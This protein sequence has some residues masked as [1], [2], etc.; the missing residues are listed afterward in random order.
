M[1]AATAGS[2]RPSVWHLCSTITFT[3][4]TWLLAAAVAARIFAALLPVR[5]VLIS[6][7]GGTVVTAGLVVLAVWL[8]AE[9]VSLSWWLIRTNFSAYRS[10]SRRAPQ[11]HAASVLRA[12][13]QGLA[14]VAL[15]C[16]GAAAI[17]A[18]VFNL[19]AV[20]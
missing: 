14:G 9:V 10:S 8:A 6:I 12:R 4:I 20:I 17:A 2:A 1:T 11:M 18:V 5:L 19:Y 16:A 3:L 7:L 13:A 15:R